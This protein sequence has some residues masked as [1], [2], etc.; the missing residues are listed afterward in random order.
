[1]LQTNS[2]GNYSFIPGPGPFSAAVTA[3]SGFEIVHVRFLPLLPLNKGYVRVERHLHEVQRPLSALCGMEL[4]IPKVLS[5]RGFDEFNRPYVEQLRSW[6]LGLD[7]TNPVARTNVVFEAEPVQE[8]MLAGCYYTSPTRA[9]GASFVLSGAAEIASREGGRQIVARGDTSPEGLRQKLDC[10]LRVL[11]SLLSEM[12][13]QWEMATAISIY[14]VYNVY[15]LL[16]SLLVPVLGAASHAGITWFHAR[17][18]VEGLDLEVDAR[19]VRHELVL[20]G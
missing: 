2:K 15:P 17:P 11:G 5:S 12:E 1:M 19:A 18:P 9:H 8:P 10:I 16:R 3:E 13:L 14:T 7:G 6:G 4:R 20:S